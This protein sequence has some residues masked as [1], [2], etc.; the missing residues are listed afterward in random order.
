MKKLPKQAYQYAADGRRRPMSRRCCA[1]RQ[2]APHCK[3]LVC[4]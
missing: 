4:D 3:E 2:T 1:P